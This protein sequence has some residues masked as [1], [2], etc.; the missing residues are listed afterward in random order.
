MGDD[1]LNKILTQHEVNVNVSGNTT[2][3]GFFSK[4]KWLFLAFI[5]GLTALVYFLFGKKSST[6]KLH[7][8]NIQ[9]SK[10]KINEYNMEIE[11]LKNEDL[12]KK[13]EINLLEQ[14]IKN[15][16]ESITNIENNIN[17]IEESI[18]NTNIENLDD[19]INFINEKYKK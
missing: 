5:G 6:R 12:S 1:K 19:A 10:N 16:N 17:G 14:E 18:D 9:N 2:N 7:E 4:I 11:Q 15:I 8:K 13:E 3:K